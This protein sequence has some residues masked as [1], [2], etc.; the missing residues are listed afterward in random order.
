MEQ[1][2][3]HLHVRTSGRDKATIAQAAAFRNM[4]VSQ[5]IL[6]VTVPAAEEVIRDEIGTVQTRFVLNEADW[7]AFTQ[8]LDEPVH[9]IPALRAL[10]NERAP[11][12]A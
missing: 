9:E 6:Q 1:K 7:E 2:A 12:D 4:S 5:F 3:E 10:L 11:W 8:R